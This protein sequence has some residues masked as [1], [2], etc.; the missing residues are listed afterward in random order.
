[1]FGI[2]FFYFFLNIW[3]LS[4]KKSFLLHSIIL[5]FKRIRQLAKIY[6]SVK[7]FLTINL[8][9]PMQ[10]L[11]TKFSLN[12]INYLCTHLY[13]GCGFPSA[14]HS[15][16]AGLKSGAVVNRSGPAD[17]ILGATEIS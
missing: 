2:L 5:Y 13:V 16:A 14:T 4:L 6:Y 8:K 17:S 12:E 7:S 15:K 9:F 11:T 3:D 1:M 10:Y